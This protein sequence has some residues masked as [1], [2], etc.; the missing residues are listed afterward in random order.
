LIFYVIQVALFIGYFIF[1]PKVYRF[2]NRQ[3]LVNVI[4]LLM[5]GLIIQTR[6][7]PEK[8]YLQMFMIVVAAVVSFLVPYILSNGRKYLYKGTWIYGIAGV[9]SLIVIL[10]FAPTSYGAKLAIPIGSFTIQ[11]SELVKVTFVFFVAGMF[12]RSLSFRRIVAT[13]A[14]AAA[15][16]LI[17]VFC[18]D[19]GT[20]LIFAVGYIFMLYVATEQARYIF[21]GFGC[22]ALASVLA[23]LLFSHVRVRV[24]T[25]LNPWADFMGD[26]WQIGQSL[27]GIGTGGFMGLGLTNGMPY[28]TPVANKDFIFSALCEEMGTLIGIGVLLICLAMLIHFFWISTWMKQTFMK[29]MAFGLS[30]IFGIQVLINAAGVIKLVPLTGITFPFLSY[31]GSSLLGTFIIIGIMEGLSILKVWEDQELMR[32]RAERESREAAIRNAQAKAAQTWAKW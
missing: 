4:F 5:I 8:A 32:E 11:A 12:Q 26:G 1:Y 2:A 30:A 27:F 19:L 31:G 18:K 6:L 7:N 24:E 13:T 22:G 15:H 21:A 25:W 28:M 9:I 14:I 16:V 23:Y 29:I 20:A 10:L 17:L 3:I